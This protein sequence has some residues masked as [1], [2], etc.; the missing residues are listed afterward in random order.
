M[1]WINFDWYGQFWYNYNRARSW[2]DRRVKGC[3]AGRWNLSW[4]D[5]GGNNVAMLWNRLRHI[6]RIWHCC[7]TLTNW[8][9]RCRTGNDLNWNG[10]GRRCQR[11]WGVNLKRLLYSCYRCQSW[12][13]QSC[14]EKIYNVSCWQTQ[15]GHLQLLHC[16]CMQQVNHALN[17]AG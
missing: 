7:H 12:L 4:R 15:Q 1:F 10:W 13:Q 14:C 8:L 16:I 6:L 9:L 11:C 2:P 17:M 3:R 5:Q